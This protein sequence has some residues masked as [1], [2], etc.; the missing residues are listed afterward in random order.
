MAKRGDFVVTIAIRIKKSREFLFL[1]I[2]TIDLTNK[3]GFRILSKRAMTKCGLLRW[4]SPLNFQ[5]TKSTLKI[6]NC[7]RLAL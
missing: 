5:Q 2:F 4:M 3:T 1:P 7:Y 6:V